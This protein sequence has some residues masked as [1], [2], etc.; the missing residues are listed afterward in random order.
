MSNI[1]NLKSVGITE[2]LSAIDYFK[3]T[4]AMFEDKHVGYTHSIELSKVA[5]HLWDVHFTINHEK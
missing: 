2:A 4:V 5:D 3:T 1:Y